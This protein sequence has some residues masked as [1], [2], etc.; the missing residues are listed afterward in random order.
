[1]PEEPV[2]F[3]PY[4]LVRRIG[5]GG[6]AETFVGLR[7]GPSSFEQ[8]ICVK[9]LL[10]QHE[11]DVQLVSL[12][13][14][15]ARLSARLRHA[16]IAQVVDFG[17]VEG[18]H[19]L[20]LELVEGCDLR[21]LLRHL[22]GRLPPTLVA[23][24]AFEV[25]RALDFAHAVDDSGRVRGIVHRD[26]SPANILLSRAGEVKLTDFGIAKAMSEATMTRTGVVKGKIAY[27]APEYA[28][29]GRFDARADLF[30]L[31]V[32]LFECLGGRRPYDGKGQIE[33]LDRARRGDRPALRALA[34]GV[35][36]ALVSVVER[37]VEPDPS[38]RFSDAR[39]FLEAL[40]GVPAPSAARRELGALVR[41]ACA[42]ESDRERGALAYAKTE[43]AATIGPRASNRP[44]AAVVP[45]SPADTT[46]TSA[47][48]PAPAPSPATISIELDEASMEAD[49]PG[50]EGVTAPLFGGAP[51]P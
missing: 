14:N 44:A 15:E 23:H 17:A 45:A 51:K 9:R 24:L 7:R 2:R 42:A 20:A 13:L 32:T 16:A 18:R 10:P 31:G 8:R 3:G 37:L 41:S 49:P 26:I 46:R 11:N 6:M 40:E 38:N 12:F 30:S 28:H 22:H 47:M 27:M 43:G 5:A 33:T 39:A 29:T 4:E 35:A 25:A 36:P 50:A 48:E 1:M 21:R 34:P 19:Y